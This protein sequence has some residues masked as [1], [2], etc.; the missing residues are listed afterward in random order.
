MM[1]IGLYISPESSQT[2]ELLLN[3]SVHID[4]AFIGNLDTSS[5][6]TIGPEGSFTGVLRCEDLVL[7]GTFRG[8]AEVHRLTALKKT[9]RFHGT[10]DTL[11]ADFT[12]GCQLA[13][14]MNIN[15]RSHQLALHSSS[16]QK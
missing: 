12:I 11:R 5:S 1:S 4:G 9:A 8:N 7:F 14:E 13:G 10:L 3:Q 16:T 6:V 2:G 15:D